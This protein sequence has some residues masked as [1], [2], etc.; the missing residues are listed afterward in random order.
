MISAT[1]MTMTK[2]MTPS[3]CGVWCPQ[4]IPAAYTQVEG[5]GEGAY[6]LRTLQDFALYFRG[7]P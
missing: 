6:V 1:T 5:F 3:R 2:L 4:A 7:G